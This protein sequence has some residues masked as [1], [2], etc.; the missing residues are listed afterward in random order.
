MKIQHKKVLLVERLDEI[1]FFEALCKHIV[2]D[3]IQIIQ[4]GGKDKFK[5]EFPVILNAPGF[6]KVTSIGIVRDADDCVDAAV[7]SVKYQLNK[8]SLSVPNGHAEFATDSD[9]N[10]GIFVMPG[11]ADNGMLENLVL[12]TVNDHPVK[13]SADSYIDELKDRLIDNTDVNFPRNESKARLHAYLSGMEKFVPSLGMAAKKGYFNLAS[14]Q[15]DDIKC[16]LE[17]L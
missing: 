6:E 15:L 3:D 17:R 4:T 11:N 12:D 1:G 7:N 8:Y 2:I 16:F 13:V 14:D 9:V 5:L 10:I